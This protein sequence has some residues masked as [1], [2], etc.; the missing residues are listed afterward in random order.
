MQSRQK[1]RWKLLVNIITFVALA[2]LIFAIRRQ[3]GQSL[4][5]LTKINALALLFMIPAQVLDYY[6]L[7]HLY[8]KMLSVVGYEVPLKKVYRIALELNFVNNVFPSGGVSSFSYF[9][10]RTKS[11]GV[12]TGK[13]TLVQM[14]KFA[15]TF[16]AFLVLLFVGLFML[17]LDGRA[18]GLLL[19]VAG[20]LVTL[21]VVSF[22]GISYI[23]GSEQRINSFFTF[24][25]RLLNRLIQVVRPKHPETIN[26]ERVRT[27][28]TDLHHSYM[29]IKGD[30]RKLRTPF[31]YA[32]LANLAEVSTIYVVYIAFGHWVNPGA[33]I[34]A[35]AVANFAGV[36]SVLPG[37]VGIYE[38]LMTAVLVAAGV[39][40]GLSIPVTV[41]YRVVNMLIQMPVGGYLYHQTVQASETVQ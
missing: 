6:S 18:S 27:A 21:M 33:V 40:A 10:L 41:M 37:G 17:A 16:M 25:A 15:L 1:F 19:L 36:I 39:P 26:V 9:S 35:Y 5:N 24:I 11:F 23:I 32:M 12:T 20:S 22:L 7:A 3:I 30:Y 14:M 29:L 38:A 34:I 2:V 8:K 4:D 13:S 28:F 31:L